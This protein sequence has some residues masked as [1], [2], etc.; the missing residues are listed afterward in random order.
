MKAMILAAGLGTRLFPLTID[1][2]KPAIPFHGRPVVGYVAEYLASHGFK[3]IIVNL[4]HQPDSVRAALGD[5]SRFGVHISY[6]EELPDILGTSGAL[7]NAKRL[8]GDETFLVINGKIITDIDLKAAVEHHKASSAIATMVLLENHKREKFTEV[9]TK[10]GRVTG[11]GTMPDPAGPLPVPLMFTGIQLLDPAVFEYIPP[12]CKSD[13]VSSFYKPAIMKG[14]NVSAYVAQGRWYEIS[15]L[16]RYLDISLAM[17]PSGDSYIGTNATI[18]PDAMVTNSVLWDGVTIE[19]HAKLNRTVIGDGVVIPGGS[20]YEN[21]AIVRAE[22]A[23]SCPD[24]PEKGNG[25]HY[26]GKNYIVP[27]D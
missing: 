1:R 6:V 7:D 8:L 25:G 24:I 11:F 17:L 16:R 19:S 13:I 18:A 14:E 9:L 2:T 22:L 12:K 5:G 26:E 20:T 3:E 21:V 23:L 10:N 27:L 4:H 15:T